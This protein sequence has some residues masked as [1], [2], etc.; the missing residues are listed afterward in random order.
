MVGKKFG[1]ANSIKIPDFN[2]FANPHHHQSASTLPLLVSM[3][4]ANHTYDAISAN[5]LAI[6]ANFLDRCPYFHFYISE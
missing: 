4:A 6:P 2:Q 3:V 5:D 1:A